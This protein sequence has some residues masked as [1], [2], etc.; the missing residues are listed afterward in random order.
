L[1]YDGARSG[2]SDGPANMRATSDRFEPLASP[3]FITALVLLVLNDFVLKP[4]FHNALTGK[5]SD[6]AGLFALTFFAATLWPRRRALA[7]CLIASAFTLWKTSYSESLID[8]LNA[9][10]PFALG[11]TVDL[12]DLVALVVIPLAAWAAPRLDPWPLPRALKL[13]LAVLAPV[14]FTATSRIPYVARSTMD[15]SRIAVVDEAALQELFDEV[16]ERRGLRCGPCEPI[17][18]RRVYGSATPSSLDV[19]MLT[20]NLDA[21]AHALAYTASAYEREG[22]RAL[23]A[24]MADVRERMAERFPD[25]AVIDLSAADLYGY[26]SEFS[27]FVIRVESRGESG[28]RS[29]E[30]LS[31][32]I[33]E[34]ARVH[35][36]TRGRSGSFYAGERVGSRPQR[37]F[38][39]VPLMEET[40]TALIVRIERRTDRFVSLQRA[41]IDDLALRLDAAFG[42]ENVTR[43]VPPELGD[44]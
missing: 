35:G 22:R 19:D 42:A 5:L 28:E 13:G 3:A 27:V 41:L 34:L 8:G 32:I 2:R 11:R 21:E 37:E 26:Q 24:L 4:V 30:T 18:E 40:S 16:A 1:P 10:L 33:D 38:A 25:I 36:L 7:G 20:V 44:F 31:S 43:H 23:H 39:V 15:A 9:M 17:S 12:T 29:K 14:A 6:F